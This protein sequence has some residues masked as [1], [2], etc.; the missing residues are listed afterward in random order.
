MAFGNSVLELCQ[1]QQH[2][3]HC[4]F[5]SVLC[6]AGFLISPCFLFLLQCFFGLWTFIQ[7]V[8][9]F[10]L[11]GE[12]LEF[13]GVC[14]LYSLYLSPTNV[15]LWSQYKNSTP[16]HENHSVLEWLLKGC[17]SSHDGPCCF[18]WQ[19]DLALLSTSPQAR[20]LCS[21]IF[22]TA[23]FL[24]FLKENDKSLQMLSETYMGTLG[25][26]ILLP[27]SQ[28]SF[29]R[30]L[31]S[32]I[33]HSFLKPC[34]NCKVSSKEGSVSGNMEQHWLEQFSMWECTC[35]CNRTGALSQEFNFLIILV[36]AVAL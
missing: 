34:Q 6:S 36:P 3:S 26:K 24:T 9:G 5:I 13:C 8:W 23:L 2:I 14:C 17:H 25:P 12:A 1:R 15:R 10:L 29:W 11:L 7:V 18:Q 31:K 19:I 32:S 27:Q 20:G 21:Q 30:S 4:S 22:S 16:G 28:W 33:N 35:P